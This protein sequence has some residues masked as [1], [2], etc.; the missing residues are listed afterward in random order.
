[1]PSGVGEYDNHFTYYSD[2]YY[3]T[4]NSDSYTYTANDNQQ[5]DVK[6]LPDGT[7]DVNPK[8]HYMDT[9]E[10]SPVSV[11]EPVEKTKKYKPKNRFDLLDFE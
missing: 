9:L 5:Y 8:D 2:Y 3:A 11:E 10:R 6:L 7:W 1:M 4:V